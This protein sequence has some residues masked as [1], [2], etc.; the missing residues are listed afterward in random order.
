M[1]EFLFELHTHTKETSPCC[2]ISAEELIIN[3]VKSGF[4][5]ICITDHF[6][7]RHFG[8]IGQI[9]WK[10]KVDAYL[11]GF[12]R[13]K[14][15]GREYNFTVILGMEYCLPKTQDDILVYGFDE[16]FL[17]RHEDLYLLNEESLKHLAKANNL[18]LIQAHPFRDMVSK[19]YD[20]LVDGF[21]GFNSHPRHNSRNDLAMRHAIEFGGVVIAGSDV[22]R[23]EDI[24]R[25]G[26]LLPKLPGDSYDLAC[27][28]RAVRTP[29]IY[30]NAEVE[31]K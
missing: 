28:L 18:L 23:V 2:K 31:Q 9:P 4:R 25:S 19:T 24:G 13:A 1:N 6:N 27:L 5:G 3:Y 16:E 7:E 30:Y 10:D 14:D 20:N 21:E 17:Y 26:V 12:R 29:G 22:H 15:I 11:K 8:S